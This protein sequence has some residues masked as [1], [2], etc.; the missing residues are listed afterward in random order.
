M[1]NEKS[2]TIEAYLKEIRKKSAVSSET[3]ISLSRSFK[4]GDEKALQTLIESNLRFVY[5]T[6]LEYVGRGLP[7][8]DLISEGNMGLIKAAKRFD[9][10]RGFKFITYAVWWIRQ[11]IREALENQKDTVRLPANRHRSRRRY[12]KTLAQL[13]QGLMREPSL[14]EVSDHLEES[15]PKISTIARGE[16]T[17]VYLEKPL[18]DEKLR[19][20]DAIENCSADNPE[21]SLM[22]NVMK[23]DMKLALGKLKPRQAYVLRKLFG[24]E[25]DAPISLRELGAEL[26]IS[27]ER[28][29]QIKEEALKKLR[30]RTISQQLETYLN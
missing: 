16:N 7:L 22:E 15:S 30:S 25:N 12:S 8:A 9:E 29:R 21:V 4:A 27:G 17:A 20:I 19:L 24:L 11:T 6:A 14:V 26:N 3:E 23:N 2:R 18:S 13:Q 28:V 10:T 5:V 1:F